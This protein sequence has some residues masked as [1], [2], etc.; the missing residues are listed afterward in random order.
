VLTCA[1]TASQAGDYAVW[2]R[3]GYERVRSAFDWRVDDGAWTAI[4][5][6]A[7]TVE[8]EELQT[9]PPGTGGRSGRA[10]EEAAA[11]WHKPGQTMQHV[12]AESVY[13]GKEM[14]DALDFFDAHGVP[15]RRT[16]IFDGEGANGFYGQGDPDGRSRLRP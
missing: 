9:A 14:P 8:V 5:P 2:D 3:V 7:D 11:L 16:G 4:K 1:L 10:D 12:W 15:V 6:D 13:S